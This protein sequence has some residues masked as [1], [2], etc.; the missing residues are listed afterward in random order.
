MQ[1]QH[2]LILA[3]AVLHLAALAVILHVRRLH[4]EPTRFPGTVLGS[5]ISLTYSP[6]RARTATE[7]AAVKP[8]A[9]KLTRPV[10]S[11]TPTQ[12]SGTSISPASANPNAAQGGDAF[13]SGNV[14]V[15]LATYFPTPKP[16][17]TQ[18]PHGTRGDVIVDVTIDEQGKVVDSQVAQSMG[19]GIDQTILATIQTWTFKPATKDGVAVSSQQELLFHYERG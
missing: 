13:G 9:A 6:G 19:A 2:R 8:T 12:A 15:A 17:L 10:K 16:D 7:K 3:S 5:H 4:I 1:S 11:F 18:L 14:T